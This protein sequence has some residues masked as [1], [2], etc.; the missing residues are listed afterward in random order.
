MRRAF[1]LVEL[2]VVIVILAILAALLFP[3]FT[4]AKE[5]SKQ[6]SCQAQLRQDSLAMQLYRS[7][8]DDKGYHH[9]MG[10]NRYPWNWFDGLAPYVKD[11]KLVWCVEP[12]DWGEPMI[13]YSFYK[14]SHYTEP[15]P[16]IGSI[17]VWTSW[18]SA[19]GRV[20][21]ICTNHNRG[22]KPDPFSL[23]KGMVLFARE[24]GSAGRI[25]SGQISNWGYQQ[26]SKQWHE[27]PVPSDW[28]S[29]VNYFRFPGESWPP[30]P[31][32]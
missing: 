26:E 5:N 4:R 24:D 32:L 15:N 28:K 7:D 11:G 18:D 22:E 23:R 21:W 9:V 6:S 31:E 19:P 14:W 30:V 12:G 29:Y 8:H 13:D 25:D 16:G 1:S 10:G 3:V 2:L 20:V 27:Q 17:Q